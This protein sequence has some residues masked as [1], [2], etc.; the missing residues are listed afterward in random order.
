MER[1]A[2]R[3]PTKRRSLSLPFRG[4]LPEW[5]RRHPR[6]AA[7]VVSLVVALAL[8]AV[9]VPRLLHGPLIEMARPWIERS[10]AQRLGPGYRV[11]IGKA[12]GS[13]DPAGLTILKLSDLA[14][15]APDGRT[16]ATV[17]MTEIA[18]ESGGLVS[19]PNPRRIEMSGAEMVI[20]VDNGAVTMSAR[21]AGQDKDKDKAAGKLPIRQGPVARSVRDIAKPPLLKPLIE[22]LTGIERDGFGGLGLSSIGLKR[23]TLVVD[24]ATN[25]QRWRFEDI[26]LSLT[27]PSEGGVAV[28]IASGGTDGPW[29]VTATISNENAEVRA[30][31]VVARD[32]SPKDLLLAFGLTDADLQADS[33]I[34]AMVRARVSRD[35]TLTAAE[36]RLHAGAGQIGPR[37]DPEARMV[38]DELRADLHWDAQQSQ[39]VI[40]P[41]ILIAGSNRTMVTATVKPPETE[42]GAWVWQL[43]RGRMELADDRPR[44]APLVLDRISGAGRVDPVD[45]VA[46]VDRIE[47]SGST[48]AVAGTATAI[49]KGPTP[50]LQLGL[51]GGRMPVH[52]VKRLWPAVVAPKVRSWVF[53]NVQSGTLERCDIALNSPLDALLRKELPLPDGGL[54]AEFVVNGGVVHPIESLPPI[55]E[56]EGH[57]VV[58]GRTVAINATRAVMESNG[59]R[60]DLSEGA[61]EMPDTFPKAA[62]VYIRLRAD[63]PADALAELLQADILQSQGMPPL[64]PATTR[65]TLS[66]KLQIALPL[67][68]D[69]PR[70]A[71]SH[72][73]DGVLTNFSADKLIHGQRLENATVRVSG[74]S[75]RGLT[76]RGEGKVVGAPIS[77][78][79]RGARQGS[80]SEVRFQTVLDDAA[81]AKFGLDTGVAS[82]ITG[83]LPIKAQGKIG[84]RE[85]RLSIEADL[86]DLAITDLIPGWTKARGRPARA[87]LTLVERDGAMRLEDLVL[88]G[89][90][91]M[92][93]G[94]IEFDSN[95]EPTLVNLPTFQLSDGD[96]ASLKLERGSDGVPR[97]TLR[98]DVFDGRNLLKTLMSGPS[99]TAATNRRHVRPRDLDIDTKLGVVVGFN[100]ETARQLEVRMTRRNGEMRAFAV[101]ARIGAD[102]S[103]KAD[104][105][106]RDGTRTNVVAFAN[107]AG[108]LLRFIDIYSKINGGDFWMFIDPPSTDGLG[109]Q[110][111]VLNITNFGVVDPGLDRLIAS[112]PAEP[113]ADRPSGRTA[114]GPVHFTKMRVN[115]VRAP[116]HMA[117]RDGVIWG[118]QMGATVEGQIDYAGGT[119]GLRGT[120]VPAYG[121]N[122][123]FA[124]IPIVGLFMGGPNEGLLGVTYEVVG[125]TNAPMLRINPLSA[126]APGFLRKLFEFRGTPDAPP[127]DVVAGRDQPQ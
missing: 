104:L 57:I 94:T 27:R 13:E 54:H 55:R 33:A 18:L 26:M 121:L 24:D 19:G 52:V 49:T 16:V 17:P 82:A 45:G 73:V 21:P 126:V 2:R 42:A 74:G 1:K 60:L 103:L 116:G 36:V 23:G 85:S 7:A 122:N 66:A 108:A 78:E 56:F 67:I 119:V 44:A 95:G 68:R 31:D 70:T 110:E 123:L 3:A 35:G 112:A 51:T 79:V 28:T 11:T 72:M 40:E 90:G 99:V 93:K 118:P 115:F 86:K 41:F 6:L 111:G 37:N 96:R 53:S 102:A 89:S 127:P 43:V 91:T 9:V 65:G 12:V 59:R 98:G 48:V 22:L 83:P 46:T 87:T 125:P 10:L 124:R 64:D 77:F 4:A 88:D 47:L 101:A 58:T 107:D 109:A 32:L 34:D 92:L 97:I 30:I 61:V 62:P 75:V 50:S 15:Q 14:V 84:A 25:G 113:G 29:S 80:D 114:R 38:L 117:L 76:L 63:G 106:V 5:L 100:G 39:I 20:Q 81:R 105:R 71:V 8:A 69:V 120:Y